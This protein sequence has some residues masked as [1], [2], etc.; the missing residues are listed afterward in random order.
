MSLINPS[1]EQ[2]GNELGEAGSWTY[3]TITAAENVAPI[4]GSGRES[5]NQGWWT[6]PYLVRLRLV[7]DT[8][9]AQFDVSIGA[10]Q[11]V[12]DFSGGWLGNQE[13][14]N[15]M[16]AGEAAP[17]ESFD[18]GWGTYHVQLPPGEPALFDGESQAVEDFAGGWRG[19]EN[20]L[21]QLG[22]VEVATF[23]MGTLNV[24]SFA[25]YREEVRVTANAADDTLIATAHG[26]TAAELVT[27]RLGSESTFGRLPG[28]LYEDYAYY[29]HLLT[30]NTFGLALSPGGTPIQI[31][32]AGAGYLFARADTQ[33]YWL[34]E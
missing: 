30:A 16:N 28:G 5:F 33:R 29:V 18:T 26:F 6:G 1:F 12:E 2:S 14:A 31:A 7:V 32:D 27:L 13:Y 4:N 3:G 15:E 34:P 11:D 19:N 25:P 10:G 8:T 23:A 20:Y 17:L 24:E 22:P 21:L 9:P